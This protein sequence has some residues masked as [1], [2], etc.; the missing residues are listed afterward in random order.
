MNTNIV[1]QIQST[2]N[3][4]TRAE[5]KVA[6]YVLQ[7]KNKV[8]YMSIT[9]LADAC[10]VGDTSVYRFCRTLGMDGYQQ[11]KMKLSISL[12]EHELSGGGKE[13]E[14]RVCSEPYHEISY[15]CDP[16]ILPVAGTGRDHTAGKDDRRV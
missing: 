5:R 2:Y 12:S 15:E 9:D 13:R 4:L 11:F 7:N 10:K 8:L 16:G 1:L 14:G 3:Q 6:D